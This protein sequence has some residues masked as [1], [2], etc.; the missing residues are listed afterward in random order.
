MVREQDLYE[1][2]RRLFGKKDCHDQMSKK[3][4]EWDAYALIL[5]FR[6]INQNDVIASGIKLS[7]TQNGLKI[8]VE[9][10]PTNKDLKVC[11]FTLAD[12]SFFIMKWVG[13]RSQVLI[14]MNSDWSDVTLGSSPSE[15]KS[16]TSEIVNKWLDTLS[17][18]ESE[19]SVHGDTDS[20]E[21]DLEGFLLGT[22]DEPLWANEEDPDWEP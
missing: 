14:K 2:A 16:E 19:T 6:T 18:Q 22:E 10:R 12:S 17:N 20:G 13:Y 9:K 7:G 5:D 3:K 8:R 4:F 11:I 15:T 1:E 21:S